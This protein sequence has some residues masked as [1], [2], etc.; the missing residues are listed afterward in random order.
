MATLWEMTVFSWSSNSWKVSGLRTFFT[1][2][3]E[4]LVP[5]KMGVSSPKQG[6]DG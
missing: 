2:A 1:S 6:E 3:G 5:Y 4:R